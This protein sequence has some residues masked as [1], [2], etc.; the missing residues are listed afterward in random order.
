MPKWESPVDTAFY[1]EQEMALR[2]EDKL[3]IANDTRTAIQEHLHPH[4]WRKV[5]EWIPL[6]GVITIFVGLLALAGAGWNYAFSRVRDEATFETRTVDRLDIIEVTLRTMRA[7]QT[8][9]PVLNEIGKLDQKTFAKSLA[10]LQAAAEH[11]VS[12]V[13]PSQETLRE[14]ANKL[15]S[16]NPQSDDY[17][18]AV[19]QFL[20]FASAGLSADV[21]PPGPPTVI[22]SQNAGNISV[23]VI[24]KRVVLLDGG[25]LENTRFENSRIIFTNNPVR[26]RNV[27]FVNCVF[28]MPITNNPSDYLKSASKILLA[29]QLNSASFPAL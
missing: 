6:V 18:P 16:T 28:Q 10:A 1:K 26:F 23:G 24:Q 14:I 20:S 2:N 12:E 7:S 22:M 29:S 5:K 27:T 21:P 19:L 13:K 15:S 9:G 25:D 3:W 4:G 17:W 8:P 11:P